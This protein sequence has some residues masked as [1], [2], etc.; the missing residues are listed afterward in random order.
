[1]SAAPDPTPNPNPQSRIRNPKSTFPRYPARV[2]Y[3][4]TALN[5]AIESLGWT[6]AAVVRL[7]L[8]VTC[9]GLIGLEREIRG[10]Q[11]GFRTHLLVCL[12]SAVVMLVSI[13]VAYYPWPATAERYEIQLDPA[14]IAYGVMAGVGFL[15]AGAIL[16]DKGN[17]RGLT[18]AAAIW[19]VA[20]VGLGCGLG[21]YLLMLIATALV[22]AALWVLDYLAKYIPSAHFRTITLRQ[23]WEVGCVQ[24]TIERLREKG[25]RVVDWSFRRADD[26]RYVDVDVRLQFRSHRQFDELERGLPDM[27]GSE[28]YELLAVKE[29]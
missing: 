11:A 22:L 16:R 2:E 23:A 24:R 9:G 26:V 6:G 20:A 7:L 4:A 27:P 10:R 13:R 17:I 5:D 12:G 25:F 3:A 1:M 8:A 14:R 18:T 15:G 29:S 21:L 19:C 28:P